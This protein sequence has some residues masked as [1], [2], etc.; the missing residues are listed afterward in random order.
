MTKAVCGLII[1]PCCT[2]LDLPDGQ[3]R[4]PSIC[5]KGEKRANP[6]AMQSF[7]YWNTAFT[8]TSLKS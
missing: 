7:D 6:K 8:I 4:M 3:K 2:G 1:V 5:G